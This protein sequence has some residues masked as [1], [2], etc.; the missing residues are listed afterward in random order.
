MPACPFCA[1]LIAPRIALCPHC[2]SDLTQ[3]R[4][5]H[6]SRSAADDAGMRMIL[7][8]GRSGW[9]IAAG[10]MGLISVLL[11]PGP[12]AIFCSIMAISHMKKNPKL[13]G[14]GRAVFGLI[15]GGLGTALLIFV[16]I[17]FVAVKP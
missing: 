12:F 11:V 15:A 14:M 5:T 8:V 6:S 17:V 2:D 9:A 3:P 1:E 4:R 10:Y 16:I 7:P 13:H